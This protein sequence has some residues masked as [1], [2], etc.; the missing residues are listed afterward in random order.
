[1]PTTTPLT[2]AIQALTTYA[3][4]TTGAS[5]TTLSA[6]VGTLVAGYGGG[7][8]SL[9]DFVDGT[10]PTGAVTLSTATSIRNHVFHGDTAITSVTGNNV[11]TI[12]IQTFME[13]INLVSVSFPN[14]T[15]IGNE[16]FRQ[17]KL[18][19]ISLPELT[20]AANGGNFRQNINTLTTVYLPKLT[21][22]QPYM[23]YD[24]E[25]LATVDVSSATSV[26]ANAFQQCYALETLDLPKVTSI[27][28]SGFYNARM[29]TTLILRHTSV[30]TLANTNAFT[31]TPLTG[32]SSRSANV[33][34][35]QSLISSYQT[36]NNW[37][38]IYNQ[39]HLTFVAIEGSQYE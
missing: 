14:V 11:L 35:P 18:A 7:G 4:E 23:F 38:N 29:L 30:V 22:I 5:D 19:S 21:T 1:M 24:D 15:S 39:G 6:A 10:A 17:C 33:Y 25:K 36:A 8:A 27:A 2:D 20:T 28:G 16:A 12:G 26:E 34:V 37:S 9:D 3:N 32:Y 13:C 31:N